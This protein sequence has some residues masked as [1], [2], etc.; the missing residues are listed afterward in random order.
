ME[1]ETKTT[2][3]VLSAD[4]VTSVFSLATLPANALPEV[5]FVGRSNTGKSS[6]LNA[7]CGRKSLAQTSKTPGR[8][9]A[10]NFFQIRC[11]ESAPDGTDTEHSVHFVD[12]P[13]YGFAR[14]AKNL[15]KTW[16]DLI[17]QY[18]T[19]RHLLK[20][21]VLLIDSR[22]SVEKEE[23]W[24]F[25]QVPSEKLVVVLT[26]IDKLTRAERES[27]LCRISGELMVHPDQIFVTSSS[28]GEG[29]AALTQY[30]FSELFAA[31]I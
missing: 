30:L 7:M 12:L 27:S 29:V 8:T 6:L 19:G 5:A 2:F 11:R 21:V 26:K 10:L 28:K 25:E 4:F 1:S 16:P 24:F 9:Q 20:N 14:A 13:G 22:R 18:L 3:R 31:E 17:D 23:H 15:R